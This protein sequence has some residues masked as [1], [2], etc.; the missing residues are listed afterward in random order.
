MLELLPCLTSHVRVGCVI[1]YEN[2]VKCQLIVAQCCTADL[3]MVIATSFSSI[4]LLIIYFDG[5]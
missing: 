2:R 4:Y 3:Y 5:P 1:H